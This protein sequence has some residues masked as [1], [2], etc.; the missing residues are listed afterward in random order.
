VVM[1]GSLVL[2]SATTLESA[3]SGLSSPYSKNF[4]QNIR[5][6]LGDS[7]LERLLPIPSSGYAAYDIGTHDKLVNVLRN[8][9]IIMRPFQP[10]SSSFVASRRT[11]L[12][13]RVNNWLKVRLT[14]N[15]AFHISPDPHSLLV[16]ANSSQDDDDDIE[17]EEEEEEEG[18]W[19]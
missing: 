16:G 14:S 7:I 10:T 11:T 18:A 8:R 4:N 2:L 9:N 3:S 13:T 1:H 5:V 15:A 6:V 12:W 17:K 19:Q